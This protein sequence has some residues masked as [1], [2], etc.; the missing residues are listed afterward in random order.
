MNKSVY[1]M[2]NEM[3]N[4]PGTGVSFEADPAEVRGWMKEFGKQKRRAGGKRAGAGD[5]YKS[6]PHR[7]GK[8]AAA[9]A[10]LGLVAVAGGVFTPAG[11][12]VYAGVK[13]VTYDLSELLGISKDLEPYRTVVGKSVSDNGY[14]VTLNDVVLDEGRL[15][16]SNTV[17]VP[18]RMES[19]EALMDYTE[20]VTVFING[21]MVSLAASGGSG[22]ADDYNIVSD[23][24]VEV[25]DVDTAKEL[26]MEIRYSVNGDDVGAFEFTASGEELALDTL[27]IPLDETVTLPD[28]SE[29]RFTRYTSNAMGQNIYF[30]KTSADYSYDLRLEGE[31]D[32]GNP[33]AFFARYSQKTEGR[34]EVE[35]IDNGYISDEAQ[36]LTLTPY[37]VKMPEGDGKMNSDYEQ[38]GEPFT[39]QISEN[40]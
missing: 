14:T 35:T 5:K 19:D 16:I 1:D 31:D 13:T 29:V 30:E 34:M 26:D 27:T 4:Q 23:W 39:I 8:Y 18:E 25:P 12:F 38:I 28:G 20:S 3:D 17:T 9:A 36:S 7:W 11:Q 21:R 6:A 24:T 22:R 37:A 32:L 15:Y 2:L 10:L 33:V 40:Q